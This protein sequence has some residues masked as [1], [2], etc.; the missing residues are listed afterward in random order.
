LAT[1]IAPAIHA[2][3]RGVRG[4]SRATLALA[5]A[6]GHIEQMEDHAAAATRLASTYQ[7]IRQA[8]LDHRPLTALYDARIRR[9]C[10]HAAGLDKAGTLRVLGLQYGGDST[11]ALPPGGDWR[12]FRLTGLADVRPNRDRWRTKPGHSRANSCI[13]QIDVEAYPS[14]QQSAKI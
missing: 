1:P 8:V 14:G 3:E 4:R 5:H 10:P 11:S 6:C 9:F 7:I 12:C 2:V 13:V